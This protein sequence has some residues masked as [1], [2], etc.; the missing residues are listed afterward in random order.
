MSTPDVTIFL[1]VE[2][3]R[4]LSLFVVAPATSNGTMNVKMIICS[5]RPTDLQLRIDAQTTRSLFCPHYRPEDHQNSPYLMSEKINKSAL[6][7]RT[8]SI[9]LTTFNALSNSIGYS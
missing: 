8:Y 3:Q 6:S 5:A 9:R 4:R 7:P 2:M 1:F